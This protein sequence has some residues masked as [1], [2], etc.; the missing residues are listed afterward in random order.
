MIPQQTCGKNGK[1]SCVTCSAPWDI[2]QQLMLV[3]C[4]AESTHHSPAPWHNL[5]AQA[6][7]SFG[8]AHPHWTDAPPGGVW[9]RRSTLTPIVTAMASHICQLADIHIVNAATA[10][11]CQFTAT[12]IVHPAAPSICQL[13]AARMCKDYNYLHLIPCSCPLQPPTVSMLQLRMLQ[14]ASGHCMSLGRQIFE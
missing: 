14:L 2:K 12:H 8:A 5:R 7:L 9:H 11:F 4:T 6:S 3:M 1:I 13:A 10:H